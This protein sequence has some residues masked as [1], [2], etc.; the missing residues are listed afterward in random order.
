[1]PAFVVRI[2]KTVTFFGSLLVDAETEVEA[3]KVVMELM[4]EGDIYVDDREDD[5]EITDC[6][7]AE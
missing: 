2:E 4:P 6:F 3:R 1:M 7:K 5:Y